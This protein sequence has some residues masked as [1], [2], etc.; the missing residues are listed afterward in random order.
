MERLGTILKET[1]TPCYGWALIP[2]HFHLL[3]RSGKIPISTVMR[4]PEA[5]N[6]LC[7]QLQSSPSPQRA[8]VSKPF[9]IH[10][11]SGRPLFKGVGELYSP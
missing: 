11:M 10:T 2:N 8:S 4:P 1:S 5:V 9:Q 7:R 3:L 6:R